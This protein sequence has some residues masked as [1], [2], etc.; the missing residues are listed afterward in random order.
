MSGV[1]FDL[2]GV[3]KTTDTSGTAKWT[4]LAVGDYTLTETDAPDSYILP[5]DSWSVAVEK[6]T[7]TTADRT[8]NDDGSVTLSYTDTVQVKAGGSVVRCV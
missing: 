4:D 2:N 1:T 6:V 3:K 7:D 5:T 8:A